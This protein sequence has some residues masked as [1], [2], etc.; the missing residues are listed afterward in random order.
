M[1]SDTE[2]TLDFYHVKAYE[3]ETVDLIIIDLLA[4]EYNKAYEKLGA[5]KQVEETKLGQ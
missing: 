3:K 2:K 5:L 4:G 1:A